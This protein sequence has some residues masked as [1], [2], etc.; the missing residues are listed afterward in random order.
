[1]RRPRLKAQ[2]APLPSTVVPSQDVVIN[3]TPRFAARTEGVSPRVIH[4]LS[5][6]QAQTES[7]ARL[8]IAGE[9][10]QPTG[11]GI[12]GLTANSMEK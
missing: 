6:P 9:D 4:F 12:A 11:V 2:P 8:A 5:P 10:S 1:M 7:A 3:S